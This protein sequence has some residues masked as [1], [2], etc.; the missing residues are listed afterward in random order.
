MILPD[1]KIKELYRV[2]LYENTRRQ[3]GFAGQAFTNYQCLECGI[4][5]VHENTNVP[6]FC[7]ACKNTLRDW[8]SN[9]NKKD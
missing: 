9:D 6:L 1:K 7:N 3:G 4:E 5:S 2:A 8:L